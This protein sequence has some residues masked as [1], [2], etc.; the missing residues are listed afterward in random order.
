MRSLKDGVLKVGDPDLEK[1]YV[2][3]D[4]RKAVQAEVMKEL[5]AEGIKMG[6]TEYKAEQRMWDLWKGSATNPNTV[7]WKDVVWSQFNFENSIGYKEFDRYYQ[8][9]TTYTMGPD[10]KIWATGVKRDFL[11]ALT[12]APLNG[13]NVGDIGLGVDGR[14]NSVDAVRGINTGM[15]A[16]EKI[17][18]SFDAPPDE[19]AAAQ[20]ATNGYTPNAWQDFGNGWRNFGRG[21]GWGGFGGF[22]GGGGGSKGT[23]FRVNAPQDNQIPYAN[24]V[25]FS[26]VNNTIIRRA[27]IRRERVENQKGRL[28]PWQ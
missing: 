10:G 7:A 8:L 4:T 26:N 5:K 13:Y 3:L 2:S 1:Y 15:R 27:S 9:N 28:K 18:E 6:L 20:A 24:D 23:P 11:A 14:L 21:G 19:I 22:G 16:L 12:M 17:N 25:P